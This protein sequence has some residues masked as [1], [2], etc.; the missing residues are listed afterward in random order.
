MADIIKKIY[1]LQDIGKGIINSLTEDNLLKLFD[2]D[3]GAN[4]LQSVL[5]IDSN[6]PNS[7]YINIEQ[8]LQILSGNGGQVNGIIIRDVSQASS[9]IPITE[10]GKFLGNTGQIGSVSFLPNSILIKDGLNSKGLENAGDYE[11]NFTDRSLI[12]KQYFEDNL[13]S[14]TSI[15]EGTNIDITGTGTTLDP[16]IINAVVNGSETKISNGITTVVT[17]NGT[18][19]TPYILE[20]VNLQKIIP[21]SNYVLNSADNNY[22]IFINNGSTDITITVPTG[23]ISGFQCGFMQ[24]GAGIVTFV[25]AVGVIINTPTGLKI[26]GQNYDAFIE[27]VLATEVY[28][29]SGDITT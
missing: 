13:P 18:I 19:A 15:T 10:I 1:E 29:L 6:L 20:T 8:S 27:K 2:S 23:L 3:Q 14:S 4:G 28:H 26:R 12:T 11:A 16:Y 21:A 7:N 22:L 25:N 5:N 24:Q 9:T 17:G